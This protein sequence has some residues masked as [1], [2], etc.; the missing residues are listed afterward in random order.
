[1]PASGSERKS[2]SCHEVGQRRVAWRIVCAAEQEE[3]AK[4]L[5]VKKGSQGFSSWWECLCEA[6]GNHMTT[7]SARGY[8]KKAKLC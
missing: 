5:M 7:A 1:M 8:R 4:G 3:Q 2:A 6:K